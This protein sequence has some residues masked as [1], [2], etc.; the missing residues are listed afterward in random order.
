MSRRAALRSLPPAALAALAAGCGSEHH[1]LDP[2]SSDAAA[3]EWLWWVLFGVSVFVFVA[4]L[5]GWSY[6]LWRRRPGTGTG[7]G[8]G[9]GDAD[10][11]PEGH[12]L[13]WIFLAGVAIPAVILVGL[14]ATTVLT[15]ARISM[16]SRDADALVVDVIGHQFWWEVRYPDAAV[17]TANEIHIPAGRPVRLR[18]AS[19]DVIHSIWIPRLHGKLDLTPGRVSELVVQADEPGTYRGFCA[20]FCGAQHALMGLLVIAEPEQEFQDWLRTQARPAPAPAEPDRMRGRAVFMRYDCHHCHRVRGG[21]LD[22]ESQSVGPDLTHLATRRTLGSV[23]VD[24]TTENLRRWIVDPHA[25]KP[26][27]LMP[28]SYMSDDELRDLVRYLE[29][30]P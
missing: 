3:I 12:A 29:G 30:L 15:G 27:V 24:N 25:I 7:T 8:A 4:V 23:T 13:R 21:G 6:A 28:P 20:E 5:V 17:V 16:A 14:T 1:I 2:A 10:P 9:A 22:E 19:N 18:L 11:E 26:G